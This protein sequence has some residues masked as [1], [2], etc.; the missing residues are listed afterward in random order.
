MSAMVHITEKFSAM[1]LTL[2]NW[3]AFHRAARRKQAATTI[4]FSD[5]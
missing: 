3:N 5:R 4:G 2:L 1:L